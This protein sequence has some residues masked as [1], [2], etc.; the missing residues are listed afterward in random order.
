MTKTLQEVSTIIIFILLL[1]VAGF[2]AWLVS[3]QVP[4]DHFYVGGLTAYVLRVVLGL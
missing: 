2:A 4:A 3:D 1:D